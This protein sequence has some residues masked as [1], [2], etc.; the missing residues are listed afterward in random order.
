MMTGFEQLAPFILV[1]SLACLSIGLTLRNALPAIRQLRGE[2]AACPQMREMRYTV[3]EP[4]YVSR[5]NV[6][7]LPVRPLAAP[8]GGQR[9]AA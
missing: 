5:I 9:A 8:R 4:A 6:V 2:L 1:G 3:R 7:Q